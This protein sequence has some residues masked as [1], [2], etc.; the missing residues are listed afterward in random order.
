MA[1]AGF[2]DFIGSKE[3]SRIAA[4]T[5]L[6]LDADIYFFSFIQIL[7]HRLKILHLSYGHHISLCLNNEYEEHSCLADK[8]ANWY[9]PCG[10]FSE[11]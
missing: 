4:R 9:N 8:N 7:E 10:D 6:P 3:T 2:L 11:N 5:I 1:G